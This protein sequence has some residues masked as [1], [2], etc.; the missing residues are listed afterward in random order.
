MKHLHK[1]FMKHLHNKRTQVELEYMLCEQLFN[2]L[3]FDPCLDSGFDPIFTHEVNDAVYE[4][5]HEKFTN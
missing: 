4:I 2:E 5:I 1:E 3:P